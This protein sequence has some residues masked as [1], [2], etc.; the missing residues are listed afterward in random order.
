MNVGKILK[1]EIFDIVC[2]WL[3]DE[4]IGFKL[5]NGYGAMSELW[6]G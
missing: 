2:V 6:A 5:T 1:T 3:N 4:Y